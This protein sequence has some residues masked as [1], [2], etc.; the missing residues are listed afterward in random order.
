[1]IRFWEDADREYFA[2]NGFIASGVEGET[3]AQLL[4][5][6]DR[7]VKYARPGAVLI[8]VGT[9]DVAENAG[10]VSD[11]RIIEN[12]KRL[13]EKAKR[14]GIQPVISSVP[15]AGGFWWNE[16]LHPAQ[17]IAALN[18][19]I[20]SWAEGEGYVYADFWTALALPDGRIVPYYATDGVHPNAAGYRVMEPI[21]KAV[22]ERALR[23]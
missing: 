23:K 16:K 2:G 10:P 20:R 4:Q 17:R 8:L 18:L 22:I 13:A 9:N 11:Q 12:L 1:M 19:K 14:E 21:A 15:P 6:F 5:R 7:D 3:S